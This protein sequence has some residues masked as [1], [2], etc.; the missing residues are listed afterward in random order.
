MTSASSARPRRAAALPAEERRQT[1]INAVLPLLVERGADLTTREIASAVGVAE[2]TLFRVFEDKAALLRAAA[3]T[4]LDPDRS[5]RALSEIDTELPLDAMV[6]TVADQLL[7]SV[8]Q[9]MSILMALR[10]S[11][12]SAQPGKPHRHGPPEFVRAWH[13]GLSDGLTELFGRY[14]AELR[15]EPERAALLMRALLFGSRQPWTDQSLALT[16]QEIASVLLT[17]VA[18]EAQ[19]R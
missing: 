10:G 17:G 1:I 12:A 19:S 18:V 6:S 4:L 16:G 14:R 5:R 2:G 8:G 15:V 11:S 9:V 7:H 3:Q 13:Q